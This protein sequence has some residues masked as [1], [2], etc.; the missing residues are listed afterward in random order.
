ML[1]QLAGYVESVAGKDDTLVT[2]AGMDTK[3]SRHVI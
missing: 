1:T 2:S 3:A